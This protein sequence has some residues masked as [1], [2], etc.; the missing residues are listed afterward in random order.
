MTRLFDTALP[1]I[2]Y[3]CAWAFFLTAFVVSM[4]VFVV[5]PILSAVNN[6]TTFRQESGTISA[7]ERQR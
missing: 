3:L 4:R 6:L 7:A 2:W 5:N 1:P